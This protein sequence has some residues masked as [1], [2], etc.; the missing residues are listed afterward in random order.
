VKLLRITP[1]LRD[2]GV[3]LRLDLNSSLSE[4]EFRRFLEET[5]ACFPVFDFIEDPFPYEPKHW[6]S[7]QK[8]FGVRLALDRVTERSE[9][10]LGSFSVWV[11]KP[12]VQDGAKIAEKA[13]VEGIPI[14]VTSY[15]D[16]TFGQACA[17]WVAGKLLESGYEIDSCG[18]LSHSAYEENLF[19]QSLQSSGPD[20]MTPQGTG[21]GF[22]SILKECRFYR[23][24]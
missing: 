13:K 4:T 12:A 17:A 10:V 23:V 16:H 2:L 6:E 8:D 3:R 15:L 11:V 21:F 18:L 5:Q 1:V 22:D 19:S 24:L 9:V 20:W 14:V 7:V